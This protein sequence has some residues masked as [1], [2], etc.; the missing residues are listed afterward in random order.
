MCRLTTPYG[1][2]IGVLHSGANA[3][4]FTR[5][6]LGIA[7]LKMPDWVVVFAGSIAPFLAV[8]NLVKC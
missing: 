2:P 5:S 8:E 3:V 6:L 1:Y 7:P 4:P